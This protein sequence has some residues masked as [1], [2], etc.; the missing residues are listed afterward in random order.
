M[1]SSYHH[2]RRPGRVFALASAIVLA[3]IPGNLPARAPQNQDGIALASPVPPGTESPALTGQRGIPRPPREASPEISSKQR[4]DILRRKFERMKQ[5]A[6]ELAELAQS[7]QEDL[8][9]SNE[10]VLS[11]EV[12]QK[13]KRIEQ[14]AKKIKSSARGF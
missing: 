3:G 14:L 8:E 9:D 11:V 10:N 2:F 12:F 13:A 5:D 4:R 7:L 6:D 1:L